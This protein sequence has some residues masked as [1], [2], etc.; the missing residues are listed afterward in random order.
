MNKFCDKIFSISTIGPPTS[1]MY[2]KLCVA[3]IMKKD[4]SV[5]IETLFKYY[6]DVEIVKIHRMSNGTLI[7]RFK[8]V[9][10]L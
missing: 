6:C 3:Y 4:V 7:L 8:V 10:D 1:M 2:L 9:G 5:F